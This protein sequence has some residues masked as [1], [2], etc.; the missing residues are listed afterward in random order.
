M[1]LNLLKGVPNTWCKILKIQNSLCPRCI[2]FGKIRTSWHLKYAH[3]ILV[4]NVKNIWREICS[5]TRTK[6]KKVRRKA[7]K[8]KL[9]PYL[10]D[11]LDKIDQATIQLYKGDSI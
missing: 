7:I 9:N 8:E 11:C 2:K 1:K 4:D 10:Q 5:I 6:N 3:G